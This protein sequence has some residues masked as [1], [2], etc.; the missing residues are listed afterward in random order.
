LIATAIYRRGFNKLNEEMFSMSAKDLGI[1][2]ISSLAIVISIFIGLK[3]L[4]TYDLTYLAT[5][6]TG[7]DIIVTALVGTAILG[8]KLTWLKVLGAITVITG[9]AMMNTK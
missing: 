5:M 6:E 8:E 3:L 7:I 1:F 4:E 2:V 9:M